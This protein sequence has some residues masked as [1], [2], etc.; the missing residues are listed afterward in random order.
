M[1]RP[2]SGW[3][4]R[5]LPPA[6]G[7][8]A[9]SPRSAPQL[10]CERLEDR[11]VPS[12][13]ILD[14]LVGGT[15][16]GT[17]LTTGTITASE[18][19]GN[20][21]ISRGA[22]TTV[23]AL[24]NISITS[25]DGI[26]FNHLSVPLTLLTGL[27]TS[28]T[29]ISLTGGITFADPTNT[30]ATTGGALNF[31]A[32]GS[33]GG[34]A[35]GSLLG[36]SVSATTDGNLT[37]AGA[38]ALG[39][40]NITLT[41]GNTLAVKG[42]LL[43]VGTGTV[44]IA[45]PVL[46]L[47]LTG[48][49]NPTVGLTN[50][51]ATLSLG[52]L[53]NVSL[54]GVTTLNA[55]GGTMAVSLN[56]ASLGFQDGS[57]NPDVVS[58]STTTGGV[59]NVTV[60]SDSTG[61]PVSVFSGLASGVGSFTLNGSNDPEAF[62]I[63]E[64]NGGLPALTINGNGPTTAPG[65]TLAVNTTNATGTTL[66]PGA[67]GAGT[68]TFTNRSPIAFT[69]IEN[70][71]TAIVSLSAS[72]PTAGAAGAGQ[73]TLTRTGPLSA[74]LTVGYTIGGTAVG[75]RDYQ[76]L[77]GTVTFAAGSATAV[78]TVTALSTALSG[79]HTVAVTVAPGTGYSPA[80]APTAVVSIT[81]DAPV[82]RRYA[83][84][85]ASSGLV[86]V[87]DNGSP[88]PTTVLNPYGGYSVGVAVAVGDVNGDGVPDIATVVA[89]GGLALVEVF[90][91]ST[92]ALRLSFFAFPASYSGGATIALGDLDG[93][94][95]DEIIVGTRTG[96]SMV[97]VFDGV[98]G[99]M[100]S[101]FLAYPGVPI[102]VNV[103][104]GDLDGTGRAEIVTAP[105]GIGPLVRVFTGDGTLVRQFFAFSPAI[106]GVG[107]TIAT[108]DLDGNG[109]ADIIAGATVGGG[110]YVLSFNNDTTIRNILSLPP[111]TPATSISRYGPP[112]AAA[113]LNGDGY[114]DLLVTVGPIFGA[115]NGHTFTL[116]DVQLPY[117]GFSGGLYLG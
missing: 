38:T 42:A 92:F 69:G 27:G 55:T 93:T 81:K 58:I 88:V 107:L 49:A 34:L 41:A 98:T 16:D 60:Q 62:L 30:L 94:G 111:T 110:N 11:L 15:L 106:A 20:Q 26:T 1:N 14:Q 70:P 95:R 78:I 24:T 53:A 67:P 105:T 115:F 79:T 10:G 89:S 114:D 66:T 101:E 52:T 45:T 19:T 32:S 6:N 3:T 80:T 7:P 104:A 73:F 36:S 44:A 4:A 90:D 17:L 59:M 2:R 82:L 23:G 64:T 50:L 33:G 56:M 71:T 116:L 91:G 54:S 76:A 85:Q 77:S 31:V 99:A 13:T 109:H 112:I 28:A 83:V 108:A 8:V 74:P 117:P 22:L 29:F 39:T 100:R 86:N 102:G 40:G 9:R 97:A 87:Y 63:D 35:L 68:Y 46:D 61:T 5:Q 12:I 103:A 72:S 47:D 18:A 57:P 96:V 37:L 84:A 21:T 43:T 75:G 25:P 113:D 51:G 48:V 65:D